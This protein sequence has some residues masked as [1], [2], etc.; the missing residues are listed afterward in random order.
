MYIP[1]VRPI[2]TNAARD[3]KKEDVMRLV[4][5]QIHG[6]VDLSP[7]EMVEAAVKMVEVIDEKIY[8]REGR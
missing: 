5:A 3:R 7:E 8:A 1:A 2:N 4:E 6:A